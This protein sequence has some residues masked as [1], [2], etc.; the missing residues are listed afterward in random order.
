MKLPVANEEKLDEEGKA[1]EG[2]RVHSAIVK[3]SVRIILGVYVHGLVPHPL[4]QFWFFLNN[5]ICSL[6]HA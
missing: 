6:A 2:F 3:V 4:K 1:Y 5:R